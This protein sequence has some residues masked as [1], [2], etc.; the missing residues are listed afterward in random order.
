[1][2]ELAEMH[3]QVNELE[4]SSIILLENGGYLIGN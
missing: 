2:N 4:T 3:Q 1:M